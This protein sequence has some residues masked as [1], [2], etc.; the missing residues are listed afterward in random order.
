MGDAQAV[1]GA[2][3]MHRSL[4]QKG[5]VFFAG[6]T[7]EKA[8][9]CTEVV[10]RVEGRMGSGEDDSPIGSK[11]RGSLF[12]E[13]RGVFQVLDDGEAHDRIEGEP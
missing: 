3:A 8:Q 12:E 10:D 1:G 11:N 6:G 7:A 4:V 2:D 9:A 13:G 5:F